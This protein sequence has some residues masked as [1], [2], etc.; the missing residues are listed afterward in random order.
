[1]SVRVLQ[2]CT[3]FVLLAGNQQLASQQN[4]GVIGGKMSVQMRT[5]INLIEKYGLHNL[6]CSYLS[7]Y[8]FQLQI[9]IF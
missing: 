9:N 5:R 4:N 8:T 7:I 6:I 2:S 3:E 1:M